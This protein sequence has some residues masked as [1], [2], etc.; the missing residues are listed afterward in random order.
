MLI[1]SLQITWKN[2]AKQK[3][4]ITPECNDQAATVIELLSNS[5]IMDT[6]VKVIK[7][8]PIVSKP[9]LAHDTSIKKQTTNEKSQ[10]GDVPIYQGKVSS[11]EDEYITATAASIPPFSDASV[12]NAQMTSE[13]THK[14]VSC[15][16]ADPT[17][18]KSQENS[19]KFN[20]ATVETCSPTDH[21]T[22][23]TTGIE[24]LKIV[25]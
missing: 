13:Q 4:I 11:C 8:S 17:H 5:V 10:D 19:Q 6:Q 1:L 9:T 15:L 14:Q 25:K 16:L 24:R 21:S 2:Q 22:L 23:T 3:Y 7:S 18:H 12:S 20:K